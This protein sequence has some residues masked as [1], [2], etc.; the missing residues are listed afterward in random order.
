[1]DQ[2]VKNLPEVKK[3]MSGSTL[4]V[5]DFTGEREYGT[6]TIVHIYV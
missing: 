3:R 1:M 5:Y 4:G 2:W 6:L